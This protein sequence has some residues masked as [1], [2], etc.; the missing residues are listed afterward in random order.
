MCFRITYE[1]TEMNPT[2]GSIDRGHGDTGEMEL[3]LF[4]NDNGPHSSP[5]KGCVEDVE[6]PLLREIKDH[7]RRFWVD[8]FQYG[9][10]EDLGGRIR[11]PR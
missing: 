10:D 11:V 1:G 4:N 9:T 5:I 6:R 3:Q 8:I 2:Y 7:P